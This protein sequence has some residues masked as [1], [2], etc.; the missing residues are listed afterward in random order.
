MPGYGWIDFETTAT[1]IPPVSGFNPN[2][3]DI[4]IPII[5]PENVVDRSFEFPWLL[6]LQVL[7]VLLVAGTAGAYAFRYGR[8]IYL[9]ALSGGDSVRSLRSMYSLLL[10]RLA[11]EGYPIK[12]ASRT[13]HE[14]A[15]EHPELE[16]FALLY[17]SLR[18]REK[19]PADMRKGQF[20]EIRGEYRKIITSARRSGF[21]GLVRR[22]FSLRDL[23]Y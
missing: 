8:L 12:P 3:T 4:V 2:S 18:Y 20:E 11:A 15:G 22:V 10:M 6:T 19:L 1:A 17:T 13:A 9:R 21:V 7:L 16:R 14:Y 5:E 23:R